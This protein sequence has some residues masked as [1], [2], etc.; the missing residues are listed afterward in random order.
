MV[1]MGTRMRWTALV[2]AGLA[3]ASL[4]GPA[5]AATTTPRVPSPA[6]LGRVADAVRRATNAPG[7]IVAGRIGH[8][9]ARIVARGTRRRAGGPPLRADDPFLTA[10]VSK[11]FTAA[12]VLA[13][14]HD[15]K[16]RLSDHVTRFVPGWDARI[17]VRMLLDHSS[18]LRS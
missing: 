10:S 18:G 12:T 5:G 13:L 16:L 2:V 7:A 4:A 14:V 8:R 3:V 15:G 9:P 1:D 11:A 17:T 6:E